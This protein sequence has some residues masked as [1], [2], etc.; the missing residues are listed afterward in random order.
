MLAFRLMRWGVFGGVNYPSI[1]PFHSSLDP[2]QIPP[3]PNQFA[4]VILIHPFFSPP[5]TPLGET[6]VSTNS[7]QIF[8]SSISS[9][10]KLNSF[11][12]SFSDK[13]K[14]EHIDDFQDIKDKGFYY[15]CL[16]HTR[17]FQE[18]L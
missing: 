9:L 17:W 5:P 1:R 18:Q 4:H 11:L 15:F 8:F 7:P 2:L 3:K 14:H 6:W 13:K 12:D 16:F 10:R